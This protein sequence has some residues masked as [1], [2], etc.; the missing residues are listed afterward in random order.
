MSQPTCYY[1]VL[2]IDNQANREEIA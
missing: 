1:K 2:G